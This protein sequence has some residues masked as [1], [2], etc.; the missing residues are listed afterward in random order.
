MNQASITTQSPPAARSGGRPPGSQPRRGLRLG[1]RGALTRT[2]IVGLA[3]V[4][5]LFFV[6]GPL[7]YLAAQTFGN[8]SGLSF[9]SFGRAY[10]NSQTPSMILN[11]VEYSLGSTA[12]ALILGT[13]LAYLVVRTD[14]PFR[15]LAF[16]AGLIPAFIPAILYAPAWIFLGS[17]DNGLVNWATK[18]VLGVSPVNIYS[19]WGMIWVEGL[20]LTPLTF[21][22]MSAAFRGQDPALEESAQMSGARRLAV[23]RRI[24]LPLARPA[25]MSALLV[26]LVLAFGSFEVPVMIGEHNS[27]YVF[28]TRIYF[29]L[30]LF[31]PDGGA[32]GALGVGL[33]GVAVLVL[34]LCRIGAKGTASYRTVT[35][36][37]FQQRPSSLGRARYFFGAGILLYLLVTVVAPVGALIYASLLPFYRVPSQISWSALTGA[38]Y[39]GLFQ[40]T[41]LGAIENTVIVGVATAVIVMLAAVIAVWFVA[42]A[43]RRSRAAA[44]LA[45]AVDGV[46]FTPIV[47][48]GLVLGLA[49]SYMYLRS[50]LPIYGTLWILIIAYGTGFIPY[51]MRYANVS[52]SQLSLELEEAAA[53][54]G[55]TWWQTF[56]R[57]VI[58]LTKPG[59]LAGGIYV[60]TLCFRELNSSILL[61]TPGQEV[62]SV[63]MYDQFQNGDFG[64]LAA[65]GI[66]MVVILL[67]LV[68]LGYRF[69]GRSNIEM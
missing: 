64:S 18:A 58:P 1:Q 69:L 48:P 10:D 66:F 8:G 9:A 60:L 39:T 35:G 12:L 46:A 13:G 3:I 52:M 22:L 5:V 29:L 16:V 56:R 36:K 63:Q 4:A 33:L 15:R 32:A 2:L 61:V 30:T 47:I 7:V 59:L 44:A 43:K 14:V 24:T 54:S 17:P 37:G 45:S 57:V 38:N 25:V 67:F 68:L 31:P 40:G 41:S 49:I 6:I 65:L 55:A 50:P 23:L 28:T 19:M 42:H 34:L 53:M 51:G 20:S 11:S 21:L 62:L 26:V 27:I